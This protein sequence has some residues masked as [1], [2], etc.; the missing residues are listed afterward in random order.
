MHVWC[1]RITLL[2][3]AGKGEQVQGQASALHLERGARAAGRPLPTFSESPTPPPWCSQPLPDFEFPKCVSLAERA[4]GHVLSS[5]RLRCVVTRLTA[6]RTLL[7]AAWAFLPTG[8]TPGTLG[9]AGFQRP[10][11]RR[12]RRRELH[13]F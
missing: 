11:T 6:A 8:P 7:P 2:M 9:L 13:P 12:W 1:V 5:G 3:T 10:E 4:P